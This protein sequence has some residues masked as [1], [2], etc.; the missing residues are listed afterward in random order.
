MWRN[1]VHLQD[2]YDDDMN[3]MMMTWLWKWWHEYYDDDDINN[4][5]DCLRKVCVVE[6]PANEENELDTLLLLGQV[7][8][9]KERKEWWHMV[10]RIWHMVVET[11]SWRHNFSECSKSAI[12]RLA[13]LHN[14][15][16]VVM[17]VTHQVWLSFTQVVSFKQ[18][19]SA[20][21]LMTAKSAARCH[22]LLKHN[23]SAESPQTFELF[24]PFMLLKQLKD[25]ISKCQGFDA[26]LWRNCYHFWK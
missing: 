26:T 3:I 18:F 11:Y 5:D 25:S 15:P 21:C 22:L 10:G 24:Q 19:V 13:F 12:K 4:D 1:G 20:T 9:M 23:S 8:L 2:H 6:A 17:V 16:A 14:Q 7:H